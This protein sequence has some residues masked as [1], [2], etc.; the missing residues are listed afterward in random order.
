MNGGLSSSGEEIPTGVLIFEQDMGYERLRQTRWLPPAL[1]A[2]LFAG[3]PW[4]SFAISVVD[5]SPSMVR[6][7]SRSFP[8]EGG[9]LFFE[10]ARHWGVGVGM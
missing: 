9:V 1:A 5:A 4:A 3:K 8:T 2:L 10:D 7:S 6:M